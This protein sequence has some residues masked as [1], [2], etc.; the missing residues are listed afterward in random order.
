MSKNQDHDE[1]AE[2]P[3]KK[4]KNTKSIIDPEEFKLKQAKTSHLQGQKTSARNLKFTRNRNSK[5]IRNITD[6]DFSMDKASNVG[7]PIIPPTCKNG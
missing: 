3:F 1:E 6:S 2:V 5:S 4:V 7:D